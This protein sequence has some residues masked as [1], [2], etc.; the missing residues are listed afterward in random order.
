MG[1]IHTYRSIDATLSLSYRYRKTSWLGLRF[2]RI[3]YAQKAPLMLHYL[4]VLTAGPNLTMGYVVGKVFALILASAGII[5]LLENTGDPWVDGDSNRQKLTYFE[6][7]YF[8]IVTLSTVGYGD[9]S[10]NTYLGRVF[11]MLIIIFGL[12]LFASY[13]PMIFDF[14]SSH[15]KYDRKFKTTPG[16]KHVV[17]TGHI[18]DETVSAFVQDFLHPDRAFN[19]TSVV[20]LAPNHPTVV[21]Q[22]ILQRYFS[23]VSY[24]VGTIYKHHDCERVQMQEAD[25]V[26]ILCDKKCTNPDA[27]DAG[28][29]TRVILVK[30]FY[31]HVRCIVQL[32]R[33]ASKAH[34]YNCPQWKESNGDAIVCIDE[35]KLGIMAQSCNAPGFSTLLANL[36]VMRENENKHY[37]DNWRET[38]LSGVSVEMYSTLLSDY[39]IGMSFP[40]AVE[41]CFTKLNLLLIAVEVHH[42]DKGEIFAINPSSSLRLTKGSRAF[43]ISQDADDVSKARFYCDRCHTN[44]TSSKRMLPKCKCMSGSSSNVSLEGSFEN[45]K[46]DHSTTNGKNHVTVS[47]DNPGYNNKVTMN[48]KTLNKFNSSSMKKKTLPPLDYKNSKREMFDETGTFFWC[49]EKLLEDAI[50]SLEVAEQEMFDGH[51]VILVISDVRA[52]SL[53]LQQLIQPLRASNQP[54][55]DL[56]KIIILGDDK[57]LA[58]EWSTINTFPDVHIVTGSPYSRVDLRAVNV[59][60]ADM[61]ILL[62]PFKNVVFEQEEHEAMSDKEVI[63]VALNLRAMTFDNISKSTLTSPVPYDELPSYK[64]NFNVQNSFDMLYSENALMAIGTCNLDTNGDTIT[65][66]NIRMITELVYD[67]N[68]LYLDDE[69]QSQCSSEGIWMTQSYACGSVFTVSV[70][71][72]LA[73]AT[74]FNQDTLTLV[75]NLVT[76]SVNPELDKIL[77]EGKKPDGVLENE[78]I[79]ATRNRCRVDQLSLDDPHFAAM[80]RINE[81]GDLFVKSIQ[82]HNMLCLGL[83]RLHT[84]SSKTMSLNTRYVIT[85]PSRDMRLEPTDRVFV[86]MQFKEDKGDFYTSSEDSQM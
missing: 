64:S 5:H 66:E 10:C 68:T 13:I 32:M 34:I 76:G 86:L 71:D 75:L 43:F 72:F 29:I 42:K 82:E 67:S 25:A 63:M 23:K 77:A 16:K 18:T 69:R 61:C 31:R 19:N 70:L 48:G 62:S 80:G 53:G 20:F 17:V 1:H 3:I 54:Y 15:T 57:F 22:S 84:N 55:E 58:R 59:H 65:G 41:I 9:F 38:Y 49:P 79:A 45:L 39:F 83:Y 11:C 52:P 81:Y 35:L 50:M 37:Q 14:I 6:C 27:E 26:I 56:K 74:Y 85:F 8:M 30:K 2:L 46:K 7:V 21:I 73:S 78:S 12:G 44:H 24:F 47:L 60:T 36:F 33:K 40:K 28:N 4:N 51:V